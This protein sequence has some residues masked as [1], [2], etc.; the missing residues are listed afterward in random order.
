MAGSCKT[1]TDLECR[2]YHASSATAARGCRIPSAMAMPLIFVNE[3]HKGVRT[4][5]MLS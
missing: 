2:A 5:G 1:E 3:G 4:F